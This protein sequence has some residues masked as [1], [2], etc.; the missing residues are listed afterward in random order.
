MGSQ[1]CVRWLP[2][3]F[4][5]VRTSILCG[6]GLWA[7]F[8]NQDLPPAMLWDSRYVWG[9]GWDPLCPIW[10]GSHGSPGEASWIL[11]I[12]CFQV[13]CRLPC[14]GWMERRALLSWKPTRVTEQGQPQRTCYSMVSV[15]VLWASN[16]PRLEMTQSKTRQ[17]LG[18]TELRNLARMKPR[19]LWGLVPI[20]ITGGFCFSCS[21]KSLGS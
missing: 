15:T 19:L 18:R 13:W 14:C 3:R 10:H 5:L 20:A 4:T 7:I 8:L 16:F 17:W 9:I 12:L 6:Q 1:V 2:E 11:G 21:R